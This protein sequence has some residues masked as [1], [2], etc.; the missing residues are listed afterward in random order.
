MGKS[1][2][3]IILYRSH[4]ICIQKGNFKQNGIYTSFINLTKL[5]HT[6]WLDQTGMTPNRKHLKGAQWT[7]YLGYIPLRS[8]DSCEAWE[9]Y[10]TRMHPDDQLPSN[11]TLNGTNRINIQWKFYNFW[12][13]NTPLPK[14]TAKIQTSPVPSLQHMFQIFPYFHHLNMSNRQKA[15][16]S[17][18][19]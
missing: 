16:P 4:R 2:T 5:G 6:K 13:Q 3:L 18:T 1:T 10:L 12:L 17:E 15:P 11:S 19:N 8:H 14:S 7:S 9:Q